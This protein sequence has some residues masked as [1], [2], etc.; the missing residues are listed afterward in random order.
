MAE[1]EPTME[2]HDQHGG[3]YSANVI[4]LKDVTLEICQICHYIQAHC[5]HRKNSWDSSGKTLTC[6]FCGIDGT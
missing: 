4:A 6:D 2:V 3:G 1:P 5:E